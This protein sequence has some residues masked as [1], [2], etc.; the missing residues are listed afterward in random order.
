MEQKI[1]GCHSPGSIQ[2]CDESTSSLT[3]PVAAVGRRDSKYVVSELV[4][5][6]GIAAIHAVAA[7]VG[8]ASGKPPVVEVHERASLSS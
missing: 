5:V 8:L 3:H 7:I 6:T 1:W 2:T 4:L